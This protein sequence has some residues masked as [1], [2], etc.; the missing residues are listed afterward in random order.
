MMSTSFFV[1]PS[2]KIFG[3]DTILCIGIYRDSGIMIY[4]IFKYIF[5]HLV[6]V[7]FIS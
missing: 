2:M 3:G 1:V 5:V 6:Q 4:S 7:Y